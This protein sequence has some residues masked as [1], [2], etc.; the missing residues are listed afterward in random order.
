MY[1]IDEIDIAII[2]LLMEDG[3]ASAAEIARQL[4]ENITER[5]VR[6]RI[7]RLVESDIIKISAIPN[8]RA[9]GYKVIAD[10][11][12]E[13]EPGLIKEVAQMLSEQETVSYVSCSIGERDISVQI[14]A[15]DNDEI[16]NFATEM[17]GKL[18][19]V[20]KT[21]TSIVPI[22]LKDVYQ[23]RVPRSCAKPKSKSGKE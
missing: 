10:I 16:Y 11:F 2:D 3:R 22:T 20:R 6:Y 7:N 15:R 8:P 23:W 14:V 21:N 19:G 13:V 18:P 5:A 17:I 4:G 12:V 9:L 1:E